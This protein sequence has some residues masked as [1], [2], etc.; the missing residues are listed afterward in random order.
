MNSFKSFKPFNRFAS[1]KSLW[2]ELGLIGTV[3]PRVSK[4][5]RSNH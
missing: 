2:T 5:K 1:F 4:F 3:A